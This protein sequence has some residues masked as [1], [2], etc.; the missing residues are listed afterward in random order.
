[1]ERAGRVALPLGIALMLLGLAPGC[2]NKN[3][4]KVQG[5]VKL[6]GKPLKDAM[7]TF[8][9][10]KGGRPAAGRTDAEGRYE[11]IYSRDH[12]GALIG[13]NTVR[14]TTFQQVMDE[15]EKERT[16]P[17][18]VPPRYNVSSELKATVERGSNEFNFDLES[19]DDEKI[20]QPVE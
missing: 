6:N 20:I 1:M 13:E 16:I 18:V 17:E 15:D 8:T 5:T 10:V 14:I 12:E 7:V 3:L 9:P 4:G 19:G 2:G 11:L